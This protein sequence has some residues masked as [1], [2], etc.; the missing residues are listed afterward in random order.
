MLH[1]KKCLFTSAATIFWLYLVIVG[2]QSFGKWLP[3]PTV[4][5]VTT[6]TGTP[7]IS[8]SSWF[9]GL[10]QESVENW[11]NARIGFRG[12]WVKTY[13]QINFSLFRQVTART[14]SPGTRIILG[15]DNYLFE[16][17]YVDVYVNSGLNSGN[18]SEKLA[19]VILNLQEALLRRGIAFVTI[20]S[21]SK[22]EACCNR[23]PTPY[24]Q[25]AKRRK[26]GFP[27]NREWVLQALKK[28]GYFLSGLP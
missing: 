8:L 11:F 5:G 1:Y 27:T 10:F 2:G 9:S 28:K 12:F 20:I 19:D 16:K 6:N 22:A 13:N 15:K 14:S 24:Q 21:P 4:S 23:L 18:S 17:W 25:I 26:V 7:V 3:E